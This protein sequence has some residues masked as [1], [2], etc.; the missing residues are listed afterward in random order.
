M[1]SPVTTLVLFRVPLLF[2][3]RV[4]DSVAYGPLPLPATTVDE[5][6]WRNAIVTRLAWLAHQTILGLPNLTAPTV[7]ELVML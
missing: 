3:M 4:C 6:T 1:H 5:R 2:G 7:A